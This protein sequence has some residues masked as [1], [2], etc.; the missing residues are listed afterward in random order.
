MFEELL[1]DEKMM[2]MG[3]Y[4]DRLAEAA[5]KEEEARKVAEKLA[6]KT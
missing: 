3:T 4:K 1:K 5:A 6:E 2:K